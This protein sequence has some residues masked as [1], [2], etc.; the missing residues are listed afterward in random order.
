MVLQMKDWYTIHM[1]IILHNQGPSGPHLTPLLFAVLYQERGG[2]DWAPDSDRNSW[3]LTCEG[4][5]PWP[6]EP[7]VRL[8]FKCQVDHLAVCQ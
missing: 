6:Y 7:C 2:L 3:Q 5:G 8:A 1:W 4:E